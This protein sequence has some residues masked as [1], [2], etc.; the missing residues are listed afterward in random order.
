LVDWNVDGKM[1][2]Q[3]HVAL[4]ETSICYNFKT[5]LNRQIEKKKQYETVKTL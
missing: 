3:E 2:I 5:D 4:G 1:L